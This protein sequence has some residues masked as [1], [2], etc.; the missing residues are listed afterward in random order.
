[1]LP[2]RQYLENHC[3][4]YFVYFCLCI[5]VHFVYFLAMFSFVYFLFQLRNRYS[6]ALPFLKWNSLLVQFC[7]HSSWY[8]LSVRLCV[9]VEVWLFNFQSSQRLR[10]FQA[11]WVLLWIP[12]PHPLLHWMK[13]SQS[14]CC[15]T[16]QQISG[17]YFEFLPLSDLVASLCFLQQKN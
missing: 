9:G 17:G 12:C 7:F 1:M 4:I 3:F 15:C 14:Q 8:L 6:G 16:S 13:P 5:F 10:L 2:H 11:L